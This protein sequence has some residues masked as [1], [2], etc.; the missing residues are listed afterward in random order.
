MIEWNLGK[1]KDAITE[2]LKGTYIIADGSESQESI[3]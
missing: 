3:I 1:E 2:P